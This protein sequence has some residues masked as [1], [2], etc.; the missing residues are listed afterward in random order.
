LCAIASGVPVI[1]A[2]FVDTCLA[3]GFLQPIEKFELKDKENE[4]RFNVKLKDVVKRAKANARH[5]L[6]NIPIYCTAEITNGAATFESIVRA[7][8]GEFSIYRGR[9]GTL[10]KSYSP[11]DQ[12]EPVY[13]L[14]GNKQDEKKLWPKFNQMATE[15][16]HEPRIVTTEWLLDTAMSQELLWNPKYL[17]K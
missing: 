4:K 11:A 12:P 1:S 14:S 6:N 10:A 5:L 17:Q 13:L 16:G 3:E 2:G 8:G 7:N 15:N 9:A